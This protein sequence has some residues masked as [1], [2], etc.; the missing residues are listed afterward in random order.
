VTGTSW[1]HQREVRDALQT[2]VSDPQLGVPTLSSAQTMSNLLKELL[3][4]APRETSVLVAAAEAGLAQVLLDQVGQGM[5]ISTA[6]SLTASAFA[7]RTPF[8]ADACCWVVV[9]LSVALGLAPGEPAA[10]GGAQAPPSLVARNAGS[11]GTAVEPVSQ[12]IK[13]DVTS[14]R[15]GAALGMHGITKTLACHTH[16]TRIGL[17]AY[18]FNT[19]ADHRAGLSRLNGLTG[20]NPSSAGIRDLRESGELVG[21]ADLWLSGRAAPGHPE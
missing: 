20:W 10:G 4:D 13:P 8:T 5:D 1:E 12:I 3:P 15:A 18:Q 2:I 19:A 9:E 7:A 14:C 21:G 6:S 17:L 11:S 16:Q